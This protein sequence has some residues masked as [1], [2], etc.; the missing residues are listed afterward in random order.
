[1]D[2]IL[3]I[4]YSLTKYLIKYLVVYSLLSESTFKNSSDMIY[5]IRHIIAEK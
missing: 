1:M 2:L 5:V 3:K 4:I